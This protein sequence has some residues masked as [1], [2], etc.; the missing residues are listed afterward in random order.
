M[1]ETADALRHGAGR[2][3]LHGGDLF[4]PQLYA[5]GF[6]LL[7]PDPGGASMVSQSGNLGI[8]L[9]TAAERRHGG[10]GKFV[11]VGNEAMID[12]IDFINYFR[13]DPRDQH[14]RG[15]HGGLRRRSASARRGPGDLP[16]Q[17][18]VVLRGASEYGKRAAASHTGALASSRAVFS[19]AARQSGMIVTTDPDE[20]M[21]LA[22]ALSYMPL[23]PGKRVAVAT[24][25]GGWGVLVADEIARVGLQTG[26][27]DARGHR[28]LNGILPAYWSHSQPHRPGLHHSRRR[29]RKRSW[30]AW[31]PATTWTPSSSWAWWAR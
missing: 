2:P 26:R 5:T 3:Q 9:L 31:W 13:T 18:V 14:H 17:A 8:Q 27:A 24:L 15:L 10:V 23:P 1:V 25:G 11:G 6:T 20:F 29:C 19:A 4:P 7:R 16:G 12:A 22:F 30:R 21:D 28:E